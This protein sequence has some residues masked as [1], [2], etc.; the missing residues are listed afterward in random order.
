MKLK[1]PEYWGETFLP[2]WKGV[3]WTWKRWVLLAL[4]ISVF[5]DSFIVTGYDDRRGEG[6]LFLILGFRAAARAEPPASVLFACGCLVALGI[7]MSH[8]FIREVSL[9][10]TPIEFGLLLFTLLS[11]RRGR[12]REDSGAN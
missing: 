6:M 1:S 7:A 9:I 12:R 4:A 11:W 8:G 10:W 3:Q 2:K 5:A